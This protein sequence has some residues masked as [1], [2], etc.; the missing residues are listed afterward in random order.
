MST[1]DKW[2]EQ[3]LE[4]TKRG[5]QPSEEASCYD[6]DTTPPVRTTADD[7][8]F[9]V[10][11]LEY[12]LSQ[13]PAKQERQLKAGPQWKIVTKT[14]IGLKCFLLGPIPETFRRVKCIRRF[15]KSALVAPIRE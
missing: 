3:Y 15:K 10:I 9:V 1:R 12:G 7:R 4:M 13:D 8:N 2:D 6:D 11:Q 14:R 5:F